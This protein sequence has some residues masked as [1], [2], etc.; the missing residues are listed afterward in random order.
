[1]TELAITDLTGVEVVT[2][3]PSNNNSRRIRL[4]TSTGEV[5]LQLFGNTDAFD[6]LPRAADFIDYDQRRQQA[7]GSA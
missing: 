7:L 5:I 2:A 1:M 3:F 4:L 6:A